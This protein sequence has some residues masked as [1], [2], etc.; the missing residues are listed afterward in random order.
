MQPMPITAQDW[1]NGQTHKD[2][3]LIVRHSSPFSCQLTELGSHVSV[4]LITLQ[5][6]AVLLTWPSLSAFPSYLDR[7]PFSSVG[8]QLAVLVSLGGC[9]SFPGL[10]RP[11]AWLCRLCSSESLDGQERHR[12]FFPLNTRRLYWQKKLGTGNK[13]TDPNANGMRDKIPSLS[14]QKMNKSYSLSVWTT[15]NSALGLLEQF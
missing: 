7:A 14:Q 1:F 10:L 11:L 2:K 8:L 13:G 9:S 3:Y 12:V 4:L 15:K 5:A 6:K